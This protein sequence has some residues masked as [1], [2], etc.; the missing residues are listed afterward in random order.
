MIGASS[1]DM[2][3]SKAADKTSLAAPPAPRRVAPWIKASAK[4]NI[5]G[6]RRIVMVSP[7]SSSDLCGSN[8]GQVGNKVKSLVKYSGLM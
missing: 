8:L 4:P 7:K 5:Y 2:M 1:A 6:N 3:I